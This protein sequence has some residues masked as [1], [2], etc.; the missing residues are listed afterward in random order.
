MNPRSGIL[1]RI[2]LTYFAFKTSSLDQDEVLNVYLFIDSL[3]PRILTQSK[4][5]SEV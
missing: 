2:S 4:R 3:C 5:E 1:R